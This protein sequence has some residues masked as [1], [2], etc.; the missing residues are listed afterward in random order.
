MAN[1][2]MEGHTKNGL[3]EGG[4]H[5]VET[6]QRVILPLRDCVTWGKFLDYSE[7]LSLQL[8]HSTPPSQPS[9]KNQL[10]KGA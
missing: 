9:K 6:P 3:L 4:G 7:A 1:K 8:T 10:P 5:V 2:D